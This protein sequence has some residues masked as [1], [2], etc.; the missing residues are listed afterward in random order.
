MRCKFA[1]LLLALSLLPLFALPAAA[2]DVGVSFSDVPET[3]WAAASIRWASEY[4][5]LEG[6]G[7]G[8]FGLGQKMSRAAYVTA[9]CR[10]MKWELLTPEQATFSDVAPGKW[11]FSAVETAYAHGAIVAPGGAFRPDEDITR[12][13]MAAM[14]VRAMGCALLSGSVQDDCPFTD[15]SAN[16][17]YIALAYRMGFIT[18]V[19]ATTFLPK[20][21]ALREEAA[22]ILLRAY[23]RLH[24]KVQKVTAETLPEGV[25]EAL[26]AVSTE[27]NIPVSPRAGYL[28]IYRAAAGSETV[29]LHTAPC[30]Q[31]VKQNGTVGESR[32]LTAEEL[33]ALLADEKTLTY[34]AAAHGSS[35]LLHR[36]KDGS[37]T[38]VWYES[39]EQLAEKTRFC[40]LLG[41]KTIYLL[42]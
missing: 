13:E 4:K 42:P 32:L 1:A 22:V 18:G 17:G 3:H 41:V 2:A 35:Y 40:R 38:V 20:A 7:N 16:Q 11:Y 28:A 15:V 33:A 25:P 8:R 30:A 5:L 10:L 36:E 14:T 19:S 24:A 27:G 6:T 12:E 9:L 39:E 26:A 34:T 23:D 21:T 31:N 37:T 29:A